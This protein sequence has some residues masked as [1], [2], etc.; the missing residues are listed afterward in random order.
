MGRRERKGGTEKGEGKSEIG[1]ED[2][3]VVE[4]DGERSVRRR[5]RDR[6]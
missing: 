6:G 5:K 4:D 3:I 1:V 2:G